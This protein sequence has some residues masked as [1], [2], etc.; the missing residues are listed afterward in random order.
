MLELQ[1]TRLAGPRDRLAGFAS[2]TGSAGTIG[3]ADFLRT[4]HPSLRV[5]A[6]EALHN[7]KYF[8]WVEQQGRTVEDL[9]RLRD[10]D[11]RVETYAVADEWDRQIDAFNAR[12][13]A[14]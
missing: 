3:A 10:P 8:T 5:A 9:H 1:R 14:G 13:A 4:R 2:A 7:L 6:V 11:F 12:V